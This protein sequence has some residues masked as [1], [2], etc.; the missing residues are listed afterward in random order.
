MGAFVLVLPA[1]RIQFCSPGYI[2]GI[3]GL[4]NPG[5]MKETLVG[6]KMRV[7]QPFR[8]E[9][10]SKLSSLLDDFPGFFETFDGTGDAHPVGTG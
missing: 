7:L 3:F 9:R 1:R 5:G 8:F 2:I 10:Q 4:K 6:S